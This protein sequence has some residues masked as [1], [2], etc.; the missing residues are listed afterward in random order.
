MLGAEDGAEWQDLDVEVATDDGPR[1]ASKFYVNGMEHVVSAETK[2]GYRIQGTPLHRIKV[3]SEDGERVWRRLADVKPGDRVPLMLGGMVGEPQTVPL[4]PLGDLHWNADHHTR[5]PR[6]MTAE[7]AEFVG[8]FMGDGS[9]HAKGI[10]LCV[11][12]GDDDVRERLL[13]LGR[14]LFGL[15]GHVLPRPGYDEVAFHSVPLTIWWDACG[16]SKR[17]P[18]DGHSGKGWSPRIPNAI[19]HSNDRDVYASFVRGLFEADGNANHG[20]AYWCTSCE[21]F[22]RDVQTL[23]LTL[24]F[25][26]TRDVNDSFS[27]LGGP[28]HRI[29]L[30]NAISADRFVRKVGFMSAR[31]NEALIAEERPQ[32]AK[33]DRIPVS[34]AQI[35]VLAP[36]ND[37]LRKEGPASAEPH[38]RDLAAIRGRPPRARRGPR[39]DRDSTGSRGHARLLL[40]H[41]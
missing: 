40:R 41:G 38:R 15:E 14:E 6:V 10:R 26:T 39:R 31:K 3:L 23:L 8:Y 16:F 35:D 27:K 13:E 7:L 22:S 25:V 2:R 24:G 34:R 33:L 19:L 5:V 9:L 4:P 12:D 36:E 21:T 20:Y 17:P 28:C 1:Q 32:T 18:F 29:R 37:D 11:A 30:L